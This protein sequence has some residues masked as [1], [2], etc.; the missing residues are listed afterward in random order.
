MIYSIPYP[1]Q[2][3]ISQLS[4]RLLERGEGARRVRSNPRFRRS[5]ASKL[6][7]VLSE[8]EACDFVTEPLQT[9]ATYEPRKLHVRGRGG[10]NPLSH[11]TGTYERQK[12]ARELG[13][14]RWRNMAGS[15]D[16]WISWMGDGFETRQRDSRI[17]TLWTIKLDPDGRLIEVC[18]LMLDCLVV[19]SDFCRRGSGTMLGFIISFHPR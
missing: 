2:L 12:P 8:A 1:P 5:L 7:G 14:A 4:I 19:G 3:F 18:I 15:Y 16:P 11:Y 6:R 9:S 13:Q 17:A 10:R